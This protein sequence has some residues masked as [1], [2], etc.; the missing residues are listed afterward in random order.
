MA[1]KV[2]CLFAYNLTEPRAHFWRGHIVVVYPA[3]IA[4]IV[5][6]VDLDTFDLTGIVGQQ[7]LQGF[8]IIALNQKIARLGVACRQIA[9]AMNQ[10]IGNLFVVVFNRLF[11]NPVQ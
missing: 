5:W 11:P 7:G 10:P 2:F 4:G 8:Q 3:F 9:I 6:W 1:R